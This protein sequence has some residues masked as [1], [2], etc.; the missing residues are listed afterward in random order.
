LALAR[1][2]PKSPRTPRV[3]AESHSVDL[4]VRG[5]TVA[6]GDFGDLIGCGLHQILQSD[7][8]IEIVARDIETSSLERIA[9]Q[10][11]PQAIVVGEHV[12]PPAVLSPQL[13]SR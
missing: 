11:A 7:E 9:R 5:I 1:G 6:L 12:A 4:A 3:D 10:H 8:H 2:I 13:R